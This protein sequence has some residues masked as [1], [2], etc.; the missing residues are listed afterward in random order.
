MP[1]PLTVPHIQRD[2]EPSPIPGYL[3]T[4]EISART[5]VDQDHIGLLI[6]EGKL[7][8]IKFAGAWIIKEEDWDAYEQNKSARGAPRGPRKK[9]RGKARG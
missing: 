3:T 5:G 9:K 7:P 2:P 1:N 4:A 6:R 8:A